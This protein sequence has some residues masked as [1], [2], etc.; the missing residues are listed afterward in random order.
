MGPNNADGHGL[1]P[2][3]RRT[4]RPA[5]AARPE[6][7]RRVQSHANRLQIEAFVSLALYGG[8]RKDEISRSVSAGVHE[9]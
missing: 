3:T 1:E 6:P 2:G 5:L 8:L 4:L 7:W 9:G